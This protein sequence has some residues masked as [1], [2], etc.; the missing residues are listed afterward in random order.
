MITKTTNY[1]PSDSLF[2]VSPSVCRIDHDVSIANTA[3][4]KNAVTITANPNANQGTGK[5]L[6]FSYDSDVT[7]AENNESQ[8]ITILSTAKSRYNADAGTK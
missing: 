3:S 1:E 4:S 7:P 6:V 2:I 8:V 5:A